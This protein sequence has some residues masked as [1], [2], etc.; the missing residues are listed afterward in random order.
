MLIDDKIAWIASASDMAHQ[1]IMHNLFFF[2]MQLRPAF[3]A[4][5][6]FKQ[7]WDVS[8]KVPTTGIC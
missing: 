4:W 7:E 5:V 3:E 1:K 6:P 8:G 2:R